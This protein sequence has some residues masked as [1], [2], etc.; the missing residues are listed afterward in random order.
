MRRATVRESRLRMIWWIAP[1]AQRP[2][3]DAL[4][5]VRVEGALDG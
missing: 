2:N 5:P 1:C 4:D 3:A